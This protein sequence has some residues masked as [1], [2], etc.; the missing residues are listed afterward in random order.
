[1]EETVKKPVCFVILLLCAVFS[2]IYGEDIIYEVTAETPLKR[3]GDEYLIRNLFKGEKVYYRGKI[4]IGISSYEYEFFI[5]TEQNER[6]WVSAKD[7]LLQNNQSL[8]EYV[9]S[10]KWI[11]NF[12][13]DILTTQNRET[14]FEY[15]PFWHDKY[16]EVADH[17]FMLLFTEWWETFSPTYFDIRNNF[18]KIKDLVFADSLHFIYTNQQQ[19]DNIITIE[20]TCY[21]KGKDFSENYINKLFDTGNKYILILKLDGDYMDFYVGD[22]NNKICTLI[23]V[24]KQFIDSIVGVVRGENVDLSQLTWPRRADGSMDYPPPQLT[25]VT[26][27]QPETVAIDTPPAGDEDTAVIAPVGETVAQQPGIGL[28]LIIVLAVA[29]IAV[30]AGVVFLVRRKR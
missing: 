30:A 16:R 11:Y 26:P 13:Q 10:K 29:G 27:E 5:Q 23:G 21:L 14:L 8:S 22:E 17:D 6:G 25:Q 19:N 12:Y 3:D 4:D 2:L 15:E 20:A 1:V 7:I 28:L 24:D 9:T 18:A